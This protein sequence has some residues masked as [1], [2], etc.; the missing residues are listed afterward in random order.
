M[1]TTLGSVLVSSSTA[2]FL[3]SIFTR[4]APLVFGIYYAFWA[5]FALT[6][7]VAVETTNDIFFYVPFTVLLAAVAGIAVVKLLNIGQLV[8]VWVTG[9]GGGDNKRAS[10]HEELNLP[11]MAMAILFLFFAIFFGMAAVACGP[12]S[13]TCAT[14]LNGIWAVSS[15][16]VG[17][18]LFGVF[19]ALALL[20]LLA[21][22]IQLKHGHRHKATHDYGSIY[23]AFAFFVVV[24]APALTWHFLTLTPPTRGL[25]AGVVAVLV[26]IL[27]LGG[28]V[29]YER[30][31]DLGKD[32]VGVARS[33]RN[34]RFYSIEGSTARLVFR[35]VIV[36]G[37]HAGAYVLGG[38]AV[39]NTLDSVP[40]MFWPWFVS[41][42]GI[43]FFIFGALYIIITI[44]FDWQ[45]YYF[46]SAVVAKEDESTQLVRPPP[47][48]PPSVAAMENAYGTRT[49]PPAVDI[50]TRIVSGASVSTRTRRR[51]QAE[52]VQKFNFD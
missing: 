34:G 9:S 41:Y 3:G 13:L 24:L 22:G 38:Y 40:A 52:S 17:W 35:F 51:V 48:A 21:S 7:F 36:I 14:F 19:V 5:M 42:Y 30:T 31:C 49:S 23:Y 45:D 2:G 46:G 11:L 28:G 29:A 20:T 47:G 26:D 37:V 4:D 32:E 18:L 25:V 15:R 50:P 12:D 33:S 39:S 27:F 16:T 43:V 44:F 1:S 8:D 6:Y 10:G